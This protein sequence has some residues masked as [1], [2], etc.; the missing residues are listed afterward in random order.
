MIRPSTR[1]YLRRDR[2]NRIPTRS[3]QARSLGLENWIREMI[4]L[5]VLTTSN[6]YR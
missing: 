6:H 4:T 5:N 1:R 3:R 2:L